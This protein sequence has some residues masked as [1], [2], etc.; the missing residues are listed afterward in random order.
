M[1][2][3]NRTDYSWSNNNLTLTG[4]SSSSLGGS[5]AGFFDSPDETEP[6][7]HNGY[8]RGQM[9]DAL[10]R[11]RNY[12]ANKWGG[13]ESGS[14]HVNR[15]FW[16][17]GSY[18]CGNTNS[19]YKWGSGATC[20]NLYAMY[21][22]QKGYRTTYKEYDRVNGL[23]QEGPQEPA[24]NGR[25]WAREFAIYVLRSQERN[26][27][28]YNQ[29]GR[30]DDCSGGGTIAC[31]YGGYN[32]G[33][34]MGTL[35]LT[36][37]VFK[38]RPVADGEIVPLEVLQACAGPD[39]GWVTLS[40]Q[41]SFHPNP[42]SRI[43]H[44]EWDMDSSD[45]YWWDGDGA[46]DNV[47][48]PRIYFDAEGQP[49][50][51]AKRK[52]R[53]RYNTPGTFTV[54]LRVV[55]EDGETNTKAFT[56]RVL[57]M[58]PSAPTASPRGPYITDA[59]VSASQGLL[60]LNG[61]VDDLNSNCGDQLTTEWTIDGRGQPV[62]QALR[63]KIEGFNNPI[64][65]L[66]AQDLQGLTRGHA[67]GLTL[68]VTDSTGRSASENTELTVYPDEPIAAWRATP[69]LAR[70]GQTVRFDASESSHPYPQRQITEYKWDLDSVPGYERQGE[71]SVVEQTYNRFGTYTARLEVCDNI[72]FCD[73]A[74]PIINKS[75]NQAPARA[76][77]LRCDPSTERFSDQCRREFRAVFCGD[78]IV[79]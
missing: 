38:P 75:K 61:R 59:S 2:R 72:P 27:G 63:N 68:S 26:T 8:S 36:P 44:Y 31:D 33:V 67:Y 21:S 53:F 74:D 37:T 62:P 25:D 15:R 19:T 16:S 71:G 43:A 57:P 60:T 47:T 52:L 7:P 9:A 66:N 48:T 23:I 12:T 77:F 29:F 20:G 76:R 49:L 40:H 55:D 58:Q 69:T 14:Y 1:T 32:L 35:T 54:T 45:G 65:T 34:T 79:S 39:S 24:I 3:G 42:K 11:A 70:C 10:T 28:D 13:S 46:L 56:V 5:A 41:S 6:F 64:G 18:T 51:G 78:S 30:I 22:H 17:N 50:D 4:D 73:Q